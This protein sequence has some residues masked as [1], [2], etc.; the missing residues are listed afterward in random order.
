MAGICAY[1]NLEEALASLQ[2]V[3]VP[4]L[5]ESVKIYPPVGLNPHELLGAI[6]AGGVAARRL[7]SL[8]EREYFA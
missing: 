6:T 8:S 7:L 3:P 2:E 4:F 5:L 1:G